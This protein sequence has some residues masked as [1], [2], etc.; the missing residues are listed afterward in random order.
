MLISDII[1]FEFHK[2]IINPRVFADVALSACMM[3][4]THTLDIQSLFEAAL[5][6]YEKRAGTNLIKNE[7]TSKLKSCTCADD[8]IAVL[9]GQAQAFQRYRGDSGTMMTRLK[10][11]VN[12]LYDLSI[13]PVVGQGIGMI[14]RWALFF[15]DATIH[16]HLV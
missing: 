10:R 7:L 1:N 4:S 5:S 8:V 3:S 14:V 16:H 12:V 15:H 6:Q 2:L 13:N 11:V 9:Q